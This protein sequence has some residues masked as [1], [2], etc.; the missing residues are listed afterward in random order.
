VEMGKPR[1]CCNCTCRLFRQ[2]FLA[3]FRQLGSGECT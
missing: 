2:G 1:R 3:D